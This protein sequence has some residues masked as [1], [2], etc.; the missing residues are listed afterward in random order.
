[1]EWNDVV[2]PPRTLA[3][4]QELENWVRHGDTLMNQ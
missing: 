1:L 3:E 4:V 2:L